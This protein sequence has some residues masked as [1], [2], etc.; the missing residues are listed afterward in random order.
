M[1]ELSVSAS[2][3][4]AGK[5]HV[6][7]VEA[8]EFFSVS[9]VSGEIGQRELVHWHRCTTDDAQSGGF[10]GAEQRPLRFSL[11]PAHEHVRDPQ[12]VEQV[13]RPVLLAA[14]VL[15]QLEEHLHA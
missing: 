4:A 15:A 10:S 14:V 8:I 13:T 2:G 7:E 11:H 6:L 5:W 12:R 9:I 3:A 1:A